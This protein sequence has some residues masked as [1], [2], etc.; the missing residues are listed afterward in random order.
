MQAGGGESVATAGVCSS[1]PFPPLPP[2]SADVAAKALLDKHSLLLQ[3]QI[4]LDGKEGQQ[5]HLGFW[6]F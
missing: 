3:P 2:L 6:A 5:G 1:A 4:E